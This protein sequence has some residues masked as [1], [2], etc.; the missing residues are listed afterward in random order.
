MSSLY[1]PLQDS[2]ILIIYVYYEKKNQTKNQT[3]LAF[4]LKYGLE[5]NNWKNLDITCVLVLNEEN[6][7]VM[8]PNLENLHV[9]Y[10]NSNNYSDYE[11][12]CDGISYIKKKND[13][14]IH[15]VYNYLCLIN[16]SSSGP[17]ME[18]NVDSHWLYPFYD[19]M[20][21]SNS[22]ACSPYM[23]YFK[24]PVLSCHFVFIKVTEDIMHLLCECVVEGNFVLSKKKDKMDAI[25]SGEFGLSI[26]LMDNSYNICC[27]F[28]ETLKDLYSPDYI[29]REFVHETNTSRLNKTIFIKNIWRVPIF[30]PEHPPICYASKPVLHDYCINFIYEKLQMQNV[31]EDFFPENLDYSLLPI[32]NCVEFH[33]YA[34]WKNKKQ[35]YEHHGYAEEYIIF[36]KKGSFVSK[37]YVIYAHYD[38]GNRIADYVINS[39]KVLYFLGYDILFYTASSNIKNI[40]MNVLPFEVNFV[41]NEGPGTDYKIL[42]T[43]LKKMKD[44]DVDCEWIMFINDSLMFPINGVNNFI[45]TITNMR[46]NCDF[47]GH[48]DSTD[49]KWHIIG[50]PLEFKYKIMREHIINF[51]DSRIPKCKDFFDYINIIETE[52]CKFLNE[53]GFEHKVV[54]KE[55][56]YKN[57]KGLACP[58]HNPYILSQWI[59]N[60]SA[61]AIKWKYCVSYL[62][63]HKVSKYFNFLTRYIYYGA[64]GLISKGQLAGSFPNAEV[65]TEILKKYDENM[66]K[67]LN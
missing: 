25:S 13:A 12:W 56:D 36:P 38:S 55:T 66:M 34:N 61:F 43:G 4:F 9:I 16:A 53:C 65:F 59:N 3:N 6:C 44:T 11:G 14:P 18:E 28:Y 39:L 48:W 58:S 20:V 41:I 54:I 7:E 67:P 64:K 32:T 46:E 23:N 1:I 17:F 35:F 24:R 51:I 47:W 29:R 63:K 15:S 57:Y 5:K 52:L 30:N 40:D 10:N 42:S 37:S 22:V 45:H 62:H 21:S 60:P 49:I 33:S 26:I 31:F 8:I 27:L 50:V 2:K 19:K